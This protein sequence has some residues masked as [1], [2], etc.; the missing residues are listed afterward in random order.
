[1]GRVGSRGAGAGLVRAAGS[2][3]VKPDER[4]VVVRPHD[5][6]VSRREAIMRT[7]HHRSHRWDRSL[8]L[9][10]LEDRCLLSYAIT[11]LC[12]GTARGT[13]TR[14]QGLGSLVSSAG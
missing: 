11:D 5:V 6:P 9:E 4:S 2:A 1:L 8:T 14:G 13:K 3:V 7:R 12:I 10:A